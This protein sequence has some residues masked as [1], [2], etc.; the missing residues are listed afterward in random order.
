VT[1]NPKARLHENGTISHRPS[2]GGFADINRQF[3]AL[4]DAH[5][6]AFRALRAANTEMGRAIQAR[7]DAI[8]AALAANRAAS[9]LIQRL[10]GD[11]PQGR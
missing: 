5:D 11:S 6:Q 9:D 4:F 3:R 1:E 7:D 8:Q 10:S 2:L